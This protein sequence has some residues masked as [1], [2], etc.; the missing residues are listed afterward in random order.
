MRRLVRTIRES[1]RWFRGQLRRAF[2][3]ALNEWRRTRSPAAWKIFLLTPRMLL[4]P[5]DQ[6]GRAGKEFFAERMRKLLRGDW[7]TLLGE[8]G[9]CNRTINRKLDGETLEQNKLK[10]AVLVYN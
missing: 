6:Q 3:I 10:Q 5:T 1:P 8:C 9:N 2:G 4:K 7:A